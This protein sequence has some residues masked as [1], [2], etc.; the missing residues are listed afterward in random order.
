MRKILILLLP[1][2]GLALAAADC[3]GDNCPQYGA[4]NCIYTG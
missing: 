3:Q 4:P 2:L 1:L